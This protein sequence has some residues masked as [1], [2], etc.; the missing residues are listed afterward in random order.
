MCQDLSSARSL[1]AGDWI[2][3]DEL[4]AVTDLPAL[5]RLHKLKQEEL[6]PQLFGCLL[7]RIAAKDSL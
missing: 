1:V 2:S 4:P 6:G 7:S 5:T 3:L